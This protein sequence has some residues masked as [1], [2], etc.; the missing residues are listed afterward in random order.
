VTFQ[1][2]T[3]ATT[4]E[5]VYIHYTASDD[6]AAK[7]FPCICGHAHD[8]EPAISGTI[9]HVSRGSNLGPHSGDARFCR[10]GHVAKWDNHHRVPR[11]GATGPP[12]YASG[13]LCRACDELVSA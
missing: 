1:E 4:S 10:D 12:R 9:S 6:G 7:R 3:C 11:S 5:L 2:A 8:L 13:W